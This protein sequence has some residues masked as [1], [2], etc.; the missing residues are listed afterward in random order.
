MWAAKTG[1]DDQVIAIKGHKSHADQLF[2]RTQIVQGSRFDI[3]SG[4]AA[5]VRAWQTNLAGINFVTH[6][7]YCNT[8]RFTPDKQVLKS[9]V[10]SGQSVR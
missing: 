8:P 3:V 10:C 5:I 1:F 4:H 7:V 9:I 2:P 6:G